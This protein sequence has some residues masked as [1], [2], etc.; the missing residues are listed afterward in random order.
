M[1]FAIRFYGA[2]AVV[3]LALVA[4]PAALFGAMGYG[5]GWLVGHALAG[6]II[7]AAFGA[8]AGVLLLVRMFRDLGEL[9]E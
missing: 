4:S 6:A 3:A 2:L 1:K 5:F 7:G 9:D 8:L